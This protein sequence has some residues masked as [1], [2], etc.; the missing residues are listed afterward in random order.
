[1]VIYFFFFFFF[2]NPCI[3]NLHTEALKNDS[4]LRFLK[5][6]TTCFRKDASKP[7]DFHLY[8][9]LTSLQYFRDALQLLPSEDVTFEAFRKPDDKQIN[10]TFT[11]I[12]SQIT[13]GVRRAQ[14]KSIK[15]AVSMLKW[16]RQ[17]SLLCLLFRLWRGGAGG[18]GEAARAGHWEAE[19]LNAFDPLKWLCFFFSS[20]SSPSF[21]HL[22]LKA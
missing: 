20:P 4:L 19:W 13:L 16:P 3:A 8:S 11:G 21:L 15:T 12:R 9:A 1:M 22:S 10:D 2:L 7:Q 5:E 14:W 6:G 17:T 18:R